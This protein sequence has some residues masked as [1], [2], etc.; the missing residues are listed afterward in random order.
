MPAILRPCLFSPSLQNL[1]R[2]WPH[3]RRPEPMRSRSNACHTHCANPDSINFSCW[4][5]AGERPSGPLAGRPFFFAAAS[6]NGSSQYR[7]CLV[8]RALAR[9][10]DE[11]EN[12]QLSLVVV[13][14]EAVSRQHRQQHKIRRFFV[15]FSSLVPYSMPK[16]DGPLHRFIALLQRT[17]GSR[18]RYFLFDIGRFCV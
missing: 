10:F 11:A 18:R 17:N 9:P 1:G 8:V 5:S 2:Q 15:F 13:E 7:S 3:R 14:V 6:W 16:V 12:S 4:S